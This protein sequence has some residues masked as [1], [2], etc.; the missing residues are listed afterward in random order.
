MTK[1]QLSRAMGIL[2]DFLDGSEGATGTD[3][4]IK[5]CEAAHAAY[6]VLDKIFWNLEFGMNKIY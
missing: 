1:D 3:E 2:L 6:D 5:D 4:E